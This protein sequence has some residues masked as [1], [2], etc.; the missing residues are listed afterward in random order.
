MATKP[1][2]KREVFCIDCG[3]VMPGGFGVE[4]RRPLRVR[5]YASEPT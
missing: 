5:S 1:L 3:M 2:P 4:G